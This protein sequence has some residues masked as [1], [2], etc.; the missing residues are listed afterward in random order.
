MKE[1]IMS[2]KQSYSVPQHNTDPVSGAASKWWF[3]EMSEAEN[4]AN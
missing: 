4:M 3:H 1:V 2:P